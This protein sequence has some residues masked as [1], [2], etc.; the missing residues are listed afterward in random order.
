[1]EAMILDRVDEPEVQ[2]KLTAQ[3]GSMLDAARAM[4][5]TNQ[6]QCEA[7]SRFSLDARALH[8]QM[9]EQLDPVRAAA[10][11]AYESALNLNKQVLGPIEAAYREVDRKLGAYHCEQE[12]IRREWEESERRRIEEEARAAQRVAEEQVR[13]LHAEEV[14]AILD[15]LPGNTP[16]ETV[17]M[18]CDMPPPEPLP[19]PREVPRPYGGYVKPTGMSFRPKVRVVVDDKY[20]LVK[21]IADRRPGTSVDLISEFSQAKLNA[22]ANA[23]GSSF[24]LPG[25]RVVSETVTAGRTAARR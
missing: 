15:A 18:I 22:L 4:V 12:R 14:E 3:A 6:E 8:K 1:M 19:V 16:T 5:V 2:T 23:L 17:R 9:H 11:K 21:A 7:A 13:A 10:Y 24:N 25:C 20:A